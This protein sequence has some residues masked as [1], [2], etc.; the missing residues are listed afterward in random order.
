M[1]MLLIIG[2]AWVVCGAFA[3][4]LMFAYFQREFPSIAQRDYRIDIFRSC[5]VALCGPLGLLATMLI[6]GA[7]H[8][9]KWR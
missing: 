9:L 4:A 6:T 3:Y 2:L 7:K 1:T 8:G 5:F